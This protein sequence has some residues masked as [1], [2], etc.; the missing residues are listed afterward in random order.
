MSSRAQFR[1]LI[2][3]GS[4]A[5]LTLANILEKL[6]VD[7]VVLEKYDKIAPNLGASIA[8]LPNGFRILDQLGCYDAI[9][10]LVQDADSFGRMATH[11]DSG[12]TISKVL[13][14]SKHL[15]K[16]LGYRPF[17]FDRQ[18]LI[19]VLY[20]NLSDKSKIIT[21]KAVMKVEQ[22]HSSSKIRVITSDKNVFEGDILVGADGIHSSVRREMWRIAN[23]TQPG[24]FSPSRETATTDYCCIFGIS[25]PN[26]KVPKFSSQHVMGKDTAY[27]ISTGPNQRLYWFLFK[28]LAVQ[29]HGL[30]EKIPRYTVADRDA[31]AVEHANDPLNANIRFG[32]LYDTKVTATLQALPE[33]VSSRWNYGRIMTIGDAAHKFNPIGGQGGNSAIED[34]AILGNLLHQLLNS[35]S[36]PSGEQIAQMFDTMQILRQDRTQQLKKMSHDLQSLMAQDN[37][38]TKFVAKVIMPYAGPENIF[39]NLSSSVR[40]GTCLDM[41]P[42]PR[43]P[44]AE[45]FYDERPAWP[46][47]SNLPRY[48]TYAVFLCLFAFAHIYMDTPFHL[49]PPTTFFGV[50]PKAYFTGLHSVDEL[51]EFVILVFADCVGWIDVGHTLQF[52]YLVIMLTPVLLI[53]YIEANRHG[54][55]GTLI[56]WPSVA[57]VLMNFQSIGRW[58]PLWFLLSIFSRGGSQTTVGR[59]VPKATARALLPAVYLGYLVPTILLFVPSIPV[60]IKQDLVLEW[61]FTAILVSILL[62]AIAKVYAKF[63]PASIYDIY[64]LDDVPYLVTAYK[65]TFVFSVAYHAMFLAFVLVAGGHPVLSFTRL[66]VPSYNSPEQF[67]DSQ[68]TAMF[69]FLKLDFLFT[70]LAMVLYGLYSIYELRYKGLATTKQVLLACALFIPAQVVVGPGAAV[71]ALWWWRELCMAKLG[72]LGDDRKL[73]N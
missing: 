41:L 30:Y 33:G 70:F 40:P 16:R 49:P 22:I 18:M 39:E 19:Q 47:N 72:G 52:L 29:A 42:V 2:A 73:K 51:L 15:Q 57:G 68:E 23:A 9:L 55:R 44:H 59:Y 35:T 64:T 63:D 65:F 32:E 3:G 26:D 71:T 7:F 1:V 20:E 37:M 17:F 45:L 12:R 21:S 66:F 48:V 67:P 31:L 27:L 61:Q 50:A 56:S 4:V 38:V 43:R 34:C 36:R 54:S 11:S 14:G 13:N 24:L 10:D 53:W 25:K 62:L 8:I 69:T 5:G 28:K 46:L 58:G 6:G 60:S